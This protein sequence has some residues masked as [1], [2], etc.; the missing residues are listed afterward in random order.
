[1]PLNIACDTADWYPS[2]GEAPGR[3]AGLI[4]AD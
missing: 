2:T 1:M 3:E 4:L